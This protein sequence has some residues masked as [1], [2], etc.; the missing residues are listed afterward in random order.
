METVIPKPM[1][2]RKSYYP[3]ASDNRNGALLPHRNEENDSWGRR[4]CDGWKKTQG[5]YSIVL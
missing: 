5:T 1:D 2:N 3:S 4:E